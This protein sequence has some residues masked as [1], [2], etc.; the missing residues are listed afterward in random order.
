[1]TNHVQHLLTTHGLSDRTLIVTDNYY[2][3]AQVSFAHGSDRVYTTDTNKIFRDGRDTQ[4]RIWGKDIAGLRELWSADALF[5][6]EDSTLDVIEKAAVMHTVCELFSGINLLDQLFLYEGEKIFSFYLA[7]GL[8]PT[9]MA[10]SAQNCPMPS[11][12]W[13]DAPMRN[14]EMSGIYTV[15]GWATNS[16]GISA[17]KVLLNGREIAATHRTISR[18]DVV[19]LQN[20]GDDP[21]APVLGFAVDID[22]RAV[23]NGRYQL[24]LEIVS[25]HGERQLAGVRTVIIKN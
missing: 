4:Y 1:M 6:T 23:G 17:V 22:T 19:E 7:T 14:E 2:T 11:L 13:L 3:A 9:D 20:A 10:S 25:G 15:T 12:S 5:I 24:S 21:Q 16:A 8:R 18:P